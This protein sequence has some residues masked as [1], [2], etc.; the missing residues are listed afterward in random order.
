M[1]RLPST[2]AEPQISTDIL[3]G[4]L[5]SLLMQYARTPSSSI[6]GNIANCLDRLLSHPQFDEP[7]QERCTYLYMRTYWR[8]VESLG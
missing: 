6:A 2:P 5:R 8:L 3:V 1:N 4:L 7:P